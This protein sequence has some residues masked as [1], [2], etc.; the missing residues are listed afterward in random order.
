[1]ATIN[2]TSVWLVRVTSLA[3]QSKASREGKNRRWQT[4]WVTVLALIVTVLFREPAL[5]DSAVDRM[6]GQI[7]AATAK[8]GELEHFILPAGCELTCRLHVARTVC[9]RAERAVVAF[10][11]AG[12]PVS[13]VV[14]RY[15]NRL[16]DL[17]F[18]L[19]RLAN[20]NAGVAEAPWPPKES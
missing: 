13:A 7:D 1:M 12:G 4:V 9:R 18:T 10:A 20:H 17:L 14:L 2:R 3:G 19:A 8:L 15:L 6:A 11:A 16:G 5:A